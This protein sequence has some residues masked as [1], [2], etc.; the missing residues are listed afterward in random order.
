MSIY[1]HSMKYADLCEA[2]SLPKLSGSQQR[3]QINQLN[4]IYDMEK[5]NKNYIIY[6]KFDDDEVIE[7]N[8]KGTY[9]KLFEY[10][11]STL[12][13]EQ[14]NNSCVLSMMDIL[15][16]TRIVNIDYPV[17][18]YNLNKAS[19][20]LD[21]NPDELDEYIEK[22]YTLLRRL[23]KGILDNLETRNLIMIS[24]GYKFYYRTE[25]GYIL[26]QPIPLNSPHTETIMNIENKTVE[27]MGFDDI[28]K[29]YKNSA[30]ISQFH[31]K[32]RKK[33]KEIY[34]QYDGYYRVYHIS[35]DREHLK[36]NSRLIY[37]QLND[38][39]KQKLLTSKTLCD[40]GE[41]DKFVLATV[42]MNRPYKIKEKIIN[43]T[44]DI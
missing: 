36:K 19:L 24:Q 15:V 23:I 21:A 44:E 13:A 10:S 17:C 11:L 9:Q 20:I 14:E 18:R 29:I 22:T 42:D 8:L 40:I 4:K 27:E 3:T 43:K 6:R 12:L 30:L 16:E 5:I 34:K 31:T 39:I 26:S 37:E 1:N 7:N 38:K 32:C 35:S 28:N 41:L 2:L 25:E 33:F